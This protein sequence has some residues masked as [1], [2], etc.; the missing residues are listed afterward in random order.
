[1]ADEDN[2]QVN[3]ID[4]EEDYNGGAYSGSK[5]SGKRGIKKKGLLRD[6]CNF[7]YL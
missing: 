1:M 2:S 6:D 4:D 5:P 3:M 7:S